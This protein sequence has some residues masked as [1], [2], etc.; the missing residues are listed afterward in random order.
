MA[1]AMSP[2]V[3][4]IAGPNGAGKTT[5]AQT[6]LPK[7]TTCTHFI[8]ADLIAEGLSPRNPDK[9]ALRAGRLMLEEIEICRKNRID[10]AFESTLSG[11]SHVR[12][13]QR[14]KKSGYTVSLF[15]LWLPTVQLSLIRVRG[16]ALRGGHDVPETII[17]RRFKRSIMNFHGLFAPMAD[18]WRLFDNSL[19]EPIPIAV[20]EKG[21]LAIME[22]ERY[23][24]WTASVVQ[25]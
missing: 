4:V 16:R 2:N 8:N 17:R 21:K 9:A 15:Y 6:F 13:I 7:Y 20:H 25:K 23:A 11:H 18:T 14:L 12:T 5:F 19:A 24:A 1:T 3:Y 22:S 10:F